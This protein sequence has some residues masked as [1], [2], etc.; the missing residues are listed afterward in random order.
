[1]KWRFPQNARIDD[2]DTN[3]AKKEYLHSHLHHD[4]DKNLAEPISHWAGLQPNK[5][6]FKKKMLKKKWNKKHD[7]GFQEGYLH[8]IR[9]AKFSAILQPNA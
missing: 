9:W 7:R 1:M 5:Y 8:L 2:A 6:A 3:K 4:R